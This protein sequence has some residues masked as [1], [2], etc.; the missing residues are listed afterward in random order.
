MAAN[1]YAIA[2]SI[3]EADAWIDIAVAKT[4]GAKIT[5]AMKN[6][7]G[8]LPGHIYGWNKGRGT[9]VMEAFRT[10]HKSSMSPSSISC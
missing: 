8:L 5:A 3:L 7:Y 6:M 10:H 1:E 4:H 2:A 9:D